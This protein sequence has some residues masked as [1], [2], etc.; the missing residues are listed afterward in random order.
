MKMK[1][2]TLVIAA[3]ALLMSY[4]EP[5]KAVGSITV[6]G[7]WA[8]TAFASAIDLNADGIAARTFD[9]RAYD[10]F[11]FIALQ[12]VADTGLVALPGQGSCSDPNALELEPYGKVTFRGY[13]GDAIFT[14]VDSSVHLCYNPANPDELMHL[15]IT[16][17]T[18]IYA[19]RTGSGTVRLHDIVLEATPEGFPLVVDTQGEFSLTI[20]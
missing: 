19:G 6:N 1:L 15:T 14:T 9:V 13:R 5:V 4:P 8:G 16:G 11:P 3:T 12:G 18:G 10:Q 20:Q 7:K 17:G 2:P